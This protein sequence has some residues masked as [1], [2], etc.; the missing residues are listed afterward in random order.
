MTGDLFM[1][2]LIKSLCNQSN[3]SES[4]YAVVEF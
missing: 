2:G 3:V 4:Y 1:L